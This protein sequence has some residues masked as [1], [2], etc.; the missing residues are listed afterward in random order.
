[1]TKVGNTP[2]SRERNITGVKKVAVI[3]REDVRSAK[4]I[5]MNYE[6]DIYNTRQ[7]HSVFCYLLNCTE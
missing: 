1:M 3:S 4:A 2:N 5:F 6:K 7:G